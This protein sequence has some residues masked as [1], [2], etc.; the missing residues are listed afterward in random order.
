MSPE[1]IG[2]MLI[3][4]KE[5]FFCPDMMKPVRT[6]SKRDDIQEKLYQILD[7]DEFAPKEIG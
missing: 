2:E 5:P 4:I 1:E 3:G 7:L 6:L